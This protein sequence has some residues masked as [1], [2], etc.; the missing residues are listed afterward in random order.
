MTA[1]KFNNKYPNE[2]VL[3]YIKN[4]WWIM[5][6][7]ALLTILLGLY[8][9]FMP[10]ATIEFFVTLFGVILV[11]SGVLGVVKSFA[12]KFFSSINLIG[13]VLAFVMGVIVIQ[14]PVGF[15]EF[16]VYLIAIFLLIKSLL[17][18]RLA[19]IIKNS[20]DAWLVLSGIIGI[21]ASIFLFITPAM[22]GLAILIVLGIYA[23]M[24]GILGIIDLINIRR[25]YSKLL[26][27]YPSLLAS[28]ISTVY[29]HVISVK[30]T[31]LR[32]TV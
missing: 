8:A 29:H 6:L 9:V 18:L 12:S 21:I 13:G 16:L 10:G 1:K 22:S 2:A 14:H 17:S 24:V 11:V 26:K 4:I 19:V 5:L 20:T 31:F 7:V 32:S 27:K 15:T 30:P 3:N 23:I 25:K 28:A